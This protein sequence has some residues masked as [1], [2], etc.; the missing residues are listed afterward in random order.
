MN[1]KKDWNWMKEKE[2]KYSSK[3]DAQEFFTGY[4]K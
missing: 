4:I 2:G 1:S 3:I